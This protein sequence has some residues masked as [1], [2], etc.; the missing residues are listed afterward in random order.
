MNF[1]QLKIV[2]RV[3]ASITSNHRFRAARNI[4]I[5]RCIEECCCKQRIVFPLCNLLII[6]FDSVQP[7]T[8]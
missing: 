1:A 5:H 4:H 7:Q 2:I 6:N 8:K 3:S